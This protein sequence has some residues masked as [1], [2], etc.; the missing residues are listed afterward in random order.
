VAEEGVDPERSTETFA[1]LAV[2]IDTPRWVGTRF[3]LRAGKALERKRKGVLICFRPRPNASSGEAAE[4]TANQLWIG[5]DDANEIRL[6]LNG[7]AAGPQHSRL[8]VALTAPAPVTD[9]PPYGHVLLDVLAGGSTLSV[10]GDEVEAAWRLLAPVL[11]A[12]TKNL[13]PMEHYAAGSSGP[14]PRG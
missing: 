2:E 7:M 5:I 11:D 14:L 9:L 1:E 12:W 4:S 13:V 10:R 6:H 3:V 8:P